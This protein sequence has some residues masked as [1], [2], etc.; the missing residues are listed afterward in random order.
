MILLILIDFYL[1]KIKKKKDHNLLE[2]L[3]LKNGVHQKSLKKNNSFCGQ[4]YIFFFTIKFP[5]T[6][7]NHS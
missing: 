6:S 5:T 2:M 7:I 3:E 4:C 1:K